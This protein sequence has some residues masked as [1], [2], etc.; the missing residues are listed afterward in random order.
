MWQTCSCGAKSRSAWRST[1]VTASAPPI[2]TFTNS[3]CWAWV[4][5]LRPP[6]STATAPATCLT[7]VWPISQRRRRRSRRARSSTWPSS[8]SLMWENPVCSTGSWARNGSSF[9]T[10]PGP[11]GTPS[12]AIL[13]TSSANTALSTRRVCAA[14][15]RWTTPLRSIPICVPSPPSTGRMCA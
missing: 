1:S 15:P 6:P 13:K 8:E 14:S 2:P 10:W 3:I 4:T 5:P 9:P 7:G 11:P 12:T